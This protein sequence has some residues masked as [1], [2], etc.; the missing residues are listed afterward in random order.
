MIFRPCLPTRV[1]KPPTGPHFIHEIKADG[2]R[3]IARR[4]GKVIKLYSRGGT[5]WSRR[6][7]LITEA[8]GQLRISSVVLDGEAVTF[9]RNGRHDFDALWSHRR[10]DEARMLAF[11][12]IELNG[13]DYRRKPLLDR[14]RRLARLLA[15]ARDGLEYVEHL[16]GDGATIFDHACR[17]GLEGIVSKHVAHPYRGGPSR[18]WRK[19]KNPQHPSIARFREAFEVERQRRA[20]RANW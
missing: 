6:Y 11:D 4:E 15:K 20:R 16:N 19:V 9:D 5:N 1:A 10:D 2:F 17:L 14:K 7:P 13:E 12:I 18:S 3:L 8:M